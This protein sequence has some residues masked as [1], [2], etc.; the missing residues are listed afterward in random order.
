MS[1]SLRMTAPGASPA[2]QT[3][4][5]AASSVPVVATVEGLRLAVASSEWFDRSRPRW[6]NTD[7]G[8]PGLV[9]RER[10]FRNSPANGQRGAIDSDAT[11]RLD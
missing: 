1:D 5:S 2:I 9:E 8:A 11:I 7:A 3:T 4:E 6:R 10:R